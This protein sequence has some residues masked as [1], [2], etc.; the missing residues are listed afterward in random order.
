MNTNDEKLRLLREQALAAAGLPTFPAGVREELEKR[1]QRQPY[2]RWKRAKARI[3]AAWEGIRTSDPER[4][5]A[6]PNALGL[7]SDRVTWAMVRKIVQTMVNMSNDAIRM[8]EFHK[9][10]FEF[11]LGAIKLIAESEGLDI[12]QELKSKT[13]P[14]EI[15]PKA[16]AGIAELERL[17]LLGEPPDDGAEKK[18]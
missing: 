6:D 16:K 10:Q 2:E 11:L 9:R 14:W 18:T 17:F 15:D 7:P 12:V 3:R 4:P 5:D 1:H 8:K 13:E